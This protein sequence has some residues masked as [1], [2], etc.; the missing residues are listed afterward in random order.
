MSITESKNQSEPKKNIKKAVMSKINCG[1]IRM[2][3]SRFFVFEKVGFLLICAVSFLGGI[4]LAGTIVFFIKNTRILKF[5]GLG[6]SGIKIFLFSL[7]LGYFFLL[8]GFIFLAIFF[9]GKFYFLCGKCFRPGMIA[10]YF[11]GFAVILGGFWGFSQEKMFLKYDL[12]ENETF[13]KEAIYGRISEFSGEKIIIQNEAGEKISVVP[14]EK[15][16]RISEIYS[17]KGKYLRA[18][19]ERKKDQENLF[20]AKKII[21]CDEN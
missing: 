10:I 14:Q 5:F 8:I 2:K 17:Q 7:P 19:G 18:V 13:Q 4:I 12:E 20:Y 21:C 3:S 9:A 11:F 15:F 16:F 6:F 1:K